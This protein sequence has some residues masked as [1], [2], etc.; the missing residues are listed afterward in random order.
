MD[1]V[2]VRSRA[3]ALFPGG[4][5]SPVRS[6]VGVSLLSAIMMLRHIDEGDDQ[7]AADEQVRDVGRARDP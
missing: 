1:N 3:G 5:N 2:E 4:V 6:S 7:P